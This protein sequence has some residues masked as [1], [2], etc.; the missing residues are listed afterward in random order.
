MD[1]KK[2][3]NMPLTE[4]EM[5][6]NLVLKEPKFRDFWTVNNIYKK[7]LQKNKGNKKFILHDGPPYANGNIHVGHA[8]NK[9]LK[10]IIVRY[11]SLKGFYSPFVLGWDTHG[12]PI[13]HKMLTELNISKDEIDPLLLRKKAAKYAKEQVEIQKEQF[14]LLQLFTN[15]DKYYITL[16]KNYEVHQL[17]VLKKMLM[18]GLVYKGLKPVF[19]SPSSQSALAES[20]VEYKDIVSPSIY[21]AFKIVESNFE[22]ININDHLLIWTT[23]PWTLIANAGVAVGSE[24]EYLRI[25]INDKFYIIAS[26]LLNRFIN[27]TNLN[28]YEILDKF[29]GKEIV[30][31]VKYKT[32]IL[33]F[34]A[35]V[36]L[37]HHVTTESGTGLVHIAPMF[38]EDDYLIGQKNNL[39][40]IMHISDNGNIY[41][42][43]TKFDGMF[44]DDANKEIS[45]FL[46]D[47][48]IYFER[49]KHS[50]PHDWRTHKPII[51]R[52]TPQW[53]VS[54]D[55]IRDKI[56]KEIENNVITYPEWPKKRLYSMIQNRSDW[57]ISR[58]RS[59]G[60]PIIV[61]YDKDNNPVIEEE[62]FDY[63]INLV[64]EYGTDIWWQKDVND[65]LPIK[66]R[67]K[68]F[69][70]ETDIMDVWF[71]SGV[72]S[73]AC[74]I[75]GVSKAPYDLYLEGSDQYRGWFNSSIINSVA[76]T[77]QTPYKNLISHGFVVDKKG[78]KMSKS[79]G[80]V[81][82]PLQ[83]IQKQGADILRMWV[84]NSEYTS[85][86]SISNEIIEQNSEIYRKIRNTLKFL[87]GNLNDFKYNPHFKRTGIHLFIQEQLNELKYN[88]IKSYDEY[89]FINVIK[90]ISNYIVEL[91]SF[92][93]SITKDILY[94]R[95]K[96][97]T[98]RMMV[99]TNMYEI[100]KFLIVSLT[101]IIP[102][103]TEEA[104]SF[105]NLENKQES[106]M[107]ET[108]PELKDILY[109]SNILQSYQEFFD[110]RSKVN[111]LIENSIKNNE[112]KRS[113]ELELF[114]PK[115]NELIQ[116]LDLKTLLMVGKITPSNELKV[117]P[118][119]SMKC[120]RCWNHFEEIEIK[121][122]LCLNCYNIIQSLETNE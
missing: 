15:F 10:D 21:V 70:K 43:K 50:Y 64:S 1:Y 84:A 9:I 45:L 106:V 7:V 49:F 66:Y 5:R 13:E 105:F 14:K 52:G 97:D 55:K 47:K 91:S 96:N 75:D 65:L 122:E 80:N 100:T 109:D 77:K 57:T 62:I 4:Y 118:F 19:W 54:I 117:S 85:D 74:D 94:V 103:T 8:S 87:L 114:L 95:Q 44:Y 92:Y 22:K 121:K 99:L 23:T 72:S 11:K 17:K 39:E 3:L 24:I 69:K 78:E 113:N 76:Y 56:L 29:Y 40:K 38:G 2:T 67:E 20:E 120:Q 90:Y 82:D 61:F 86:V 59:W 58:Q 102:T 36:V 53:F 104:Y 34:I 81:V 33:D 116:T 51:F 12:L 83:I 110:L 26:E 37:G 25:K 63:V 30:D 35:P 28:G 71:D 89:K 68:G 16:D 88:V 18:D 73:I 119:E 60:V 111:I 41:N 27:K 32:P 93:L 48:L 42:T 46:G 79:K 108:L 98:E 6:A 31:K 112:V 115:Q 101:P 107:L